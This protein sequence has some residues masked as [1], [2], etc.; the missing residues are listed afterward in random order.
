MSRLLVFSVM[1]A[2]SKDLPMYRYY[3][4]SLI[5]VKQETLGINSEFKDSKH[6]SHTTQQFHLRVC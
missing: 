2:E 5:R 6:G 4:N 1:K 3:C